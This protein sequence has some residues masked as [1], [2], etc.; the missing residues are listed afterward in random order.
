MNS[1]AMT[2]VLDGGEVAVVNAR[3]ASKSPRLCRF[4]VHEWRA[5]EDPDW[6]SCHACVHC[7]R[8]RSIRSRLN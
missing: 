2:A 8:V 6:G 3:L 7:D 1:N 4:G 5:I